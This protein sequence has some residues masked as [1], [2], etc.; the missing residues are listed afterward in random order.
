MNVLYSINNRE[1]NLEDK[2]EY[3]RLLKL[4]YNNLRKNYSELTDTV[5]GEGYY[6]LAMDI[7]TCDNIVADDIKRE[8]RYL[9]HD[10]KIYKRLF[11]I[12]LI[13]IIALVIY[14]FIK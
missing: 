7:Y 2:D 8:F 5:L 6:N 1:I 11:I 13:I 4:K 14:I 10:L 12:S 9:K 3:I